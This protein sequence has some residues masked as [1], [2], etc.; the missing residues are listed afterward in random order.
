MKRQINAGYGCVNN[1]SVFRIALPFWALVVKH[2][3]DEV[4]RSQHEMFRN[5]L[6]AREG[7][8]DSSS[9]RDSSTS[10]IVNAEGSQVG[11]LTTTN[12]SRSGGNV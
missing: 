7:K 12:L 9:G 4:N 5:R 3:R 11:V 8:G 1:G 2:V 6:G 10:S